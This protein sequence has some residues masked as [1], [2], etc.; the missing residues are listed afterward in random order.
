MIQYDINLRSMFVAYHIGTGGLDLVKMLSMIG[1]GVGLS[2]ER[3]FPINMSYI[4]QQ[5]L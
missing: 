3:S 5:S 4:H 2:Y 1:C